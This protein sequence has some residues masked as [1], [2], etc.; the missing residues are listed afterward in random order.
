L[1]GKF[2]ETGMAQVR[3]SLLI[4]VLTEPPTTEEADA[5]PVVGTTGTNFASSGLPAGQD[6]PGAGRPARPPDW[7]LRVLEALAQA[8]QLD[9]A[10]R[11]YLFA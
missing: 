6:H 3:E 1:L 8:L 11:A 2:K 9:E 4:Q 5:A 10:E 7:S